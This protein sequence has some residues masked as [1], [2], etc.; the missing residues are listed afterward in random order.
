MAWLQTD[1][2]GNFHISFRFGGQ[3]FKRSLKTKSEKQAQRNKVRFEDTILGGK[4]QI[5][6]TNGSLPCELVEV[7]N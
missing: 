1:P 7:S 4:E 6:P 2:S 5:E 3:K